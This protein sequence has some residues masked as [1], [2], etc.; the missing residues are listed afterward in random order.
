[1]KDALMELRDVNAGYGDKCLLRGV[2]LT[3]GGG[4]MV[5]M[6]G[7][8]GAGKST[9]LRTICGELAP[10][11][12]TVSVCGIDT[13]SGG[14]ARLARVLSMV[15]TDRVVQE[16]LSVRDVVAMGRYPYTGFFGRLDRDD[17]RIVDEALAAVGM[18]G[19]MNRS[20]ASLSDG[21]RQKVMVARALAQDTPVVILDEPTAFLD[22]ASRV[23]LNALLAS[24]VREQGKAVVMSS[25]DVAQA[26]EQST[27][28]WLLPGD[29]KLI[30][31]TPSELLAAHSSDPSTS[32]LDRLFAGRAVTF[33]ASR[34]DYVGVEVEK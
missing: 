21:E 33:D 20:I 25:H 14:R 17:N 7:A 29:G 8:N 22:V 26:L 9:L 23:E 30:D 12:G 10:L 16:G 1:M 27:R 15:T 5:T 3:V 31:A 32:P 19:Y 34:M 4:E 11:G 18:T 2:T 6:L 13:H 28:V 24:L